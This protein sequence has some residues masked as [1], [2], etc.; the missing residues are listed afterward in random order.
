M[1]VCSLK[2]RL[3][4][5]LFS[6]ADI[7]GAEALKELDVDQIVAQH[8]RDFVGMQSVKAFVR[9]IASQKAD[10]DERSEVGLQT[11][12]T[13]KLN[14]ILTGNPGTGKTT[15]ARKLGRDV[16]CNFSLRPISSSVSARISSANIQS[17][18]KREHG[19]VL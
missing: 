19:Q 11:Q 5:R 13:M 2:A 10:M 16:V 8:G 9:E 1:S 17:S 6:R 14:I 12:Q 15:V 4:D 3:E 18:L 7:E